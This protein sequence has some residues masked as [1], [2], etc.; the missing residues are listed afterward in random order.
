MAHIGEV[1]GTAI[2]SPRQNLHLMNL[3]VFLEVF[4]VA[5]L[6]AWCQGSGGATTAA[7]SFF[8]FPFFE[9]G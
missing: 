3:V 7:P 5:H 9:V 1:R 6:S 4:K 8:C 2:A